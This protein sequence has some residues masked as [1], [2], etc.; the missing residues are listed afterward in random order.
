MHTRHVREISCL[1]I[2]CFCMC[3]Y[4]F[5]APIYYSEQYSANQTSVALYALYA[6]RAILV[7][8]C[9]CALVLCCPLFWPSH[10]TS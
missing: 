1:V 2:N 10:G 7:P 5:C 3:F 4:Y 9:V 8:S 6:I